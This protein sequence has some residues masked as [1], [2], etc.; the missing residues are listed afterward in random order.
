[1]AVV[2]PS[3][4]SRDL[5]EYRAAVLE[6]CRALN[7]GVATMEDFAATGLGATRGSLDQLDRCDVYLGVFAHRYGYVEPGYPHSVTEAEYE[8][9]KRR[10]GIR[11][12]HVSASVFG[13]AWMAIA[14]LVG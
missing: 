13:P 1:V 3:S 9:A 5:P 8:H 14:L 2:F 12:R 11:C 7:L 6:A 10:G 4:T